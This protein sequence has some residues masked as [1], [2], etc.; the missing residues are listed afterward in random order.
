MAIQSRRVPS[1]RQRA[2]ELAVN[3]RALARGYRYAQRWPDPGA[4]SPGKA[5]RLERYFD[6]H[7]AGPG[8]WKWRHYFEIYERHLGK[9]VGEEVHVAEIGVYS[10]GSLQM[11][12]EYFGPRAQI[13]GVDIEPACRAYEAERTEIFIGDQADPAFWA[14]FTAAVPKLDVV[15]DDGGHHAHQQIA[16]LE[17]LLPHLRPGGVLICEDIHSPKHAFHAYVDGLARQLHEIHDPESDMFRFAPRPFQSAIQSIHTYPFVTVVEKRGQPLDFIEA[18]RR[19]TQWQPFY[20]P[21]T[22]PEP[23]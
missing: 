7:T 18:P 21:A 8:L 10:G 5:G 1:L 14:Q 13:Y 11:W 22:V 23:T 3:A 4:R 6:D 19:G 17:A 9:F 16:T 20:D 12:R 15:L 2:A